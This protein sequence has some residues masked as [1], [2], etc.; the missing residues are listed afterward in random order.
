M[1]LKSTYNKIAEDWF[2]D[3]DADTWWYSGT[4]KFLSLLPKDATILDIGCGA[5]QKTRYISKKG[6]K[7]IGADFSEKMIE[8]A[9]KQAPEINFEVLDIYEIDK[10]HKTFD[11]IF[12]QAVLLHIPKARVE[13][14]LLKIKSRLNQNGLLYIAVKAVRDDGIEEHTKQE[15]DYGYKYERFFSYYTMSELEKYLSNLN[16]EVIWKTSTASGHV[17]WLQIIG[18]L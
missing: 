9:Q 2:R 14:V 12:A 16:M 3:H 15:N 4:D 1:D 17:E 5:G 11:A 8:I 18:I 6:Y 10:F 7:V 13:E